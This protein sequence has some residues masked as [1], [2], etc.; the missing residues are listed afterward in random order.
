[1]A[2]KR[3]LELRTGRG[4]KMSLKLPPASQEDDITRL[5][6]QLTKS[7][8]RTTYLQQKRLNKFTKK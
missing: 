6:I 3:L 4:G 2:D 8:S 7:V 1:M 5:E